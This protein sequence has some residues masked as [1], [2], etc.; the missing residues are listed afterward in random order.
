MTPVPSSTDVDPAAL[1]AA[2]RR[3][4]HRLAADPRIGTVSRIEVT[5]CGRGSIER[6]FAVEAAL[7]AA[8]PMGKR[9]P[10]HDLVSSTGEM[11]PSAALT[12]RAI[13]LDGEEVMRG[14]YDPAS[15]RVRSGAM[16]ADVHG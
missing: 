3:F 11:G 15:A 9:R 14:V 4:A 10:A 8:W 6:L 5:L 13:G 16:V 2:T 12:L 1:A 7:V